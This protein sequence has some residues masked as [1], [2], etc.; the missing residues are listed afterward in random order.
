MHEVGISIGNQTWLKLRPQRVTGSGKL[1]PRLVFDLEATTPRE[2]MEVQIQ[3]LQARLLVS[4]EVAGYGSFTGAVVGPW[5][6]SVRLEVP[7]SASALDFIDAELVGE[8]I[9]LTLEVSGILYGKNDNDDV[10]RHAS[11]PK[12]GEWTSLCFGTSTTVALPFE[13]ARSDWF[14]NVRGPLG[15]LRYLFVEIPLP[16]DS[17]PL[18]AAGDRLRDAER[19]LVM[20]HEAEVFAQCRGAIDALPGAKKNIFDNVTNRD[21]AAALDALV[22]H[23]GNYLHHGRHVGPEGSFPVTGQ[24]ARFALNLTKVIISHVAQ[25]AMRN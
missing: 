21:E 15:S 7:I 22:L 1:M 6:T 23:A 13:A 17:G 10:P 2:R 14:T 18:A 24:D 11:S 16:K 20:G 25:I 4:D 5:G 12:P 19:A 3:Q 9:A 8:R